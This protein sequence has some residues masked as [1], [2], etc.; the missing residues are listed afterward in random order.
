M[1][2]IWLNAHTQEADVYS[3]FYDLCALAKCSENNDLG[4]YG[5]Y[6]DLG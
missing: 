6:G 1:Q 2:A 4:G 3:F 5:M